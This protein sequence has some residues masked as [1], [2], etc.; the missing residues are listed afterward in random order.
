[1][2]KQ[3]LPSGLGLIRVPTFEEGP[4]HS[5]VTEFDAA[6]DQ[7]LDAPGL[8]LDLRG[9]SG[10]S[11][12]IS[13]RAAGRFLDESFTYGRESYRVRL[14]QRGWLQSHACR[15]R[16]RSPVYTGPV[17]VLIDS[18]TMS[19]AE[20]FLAVLVDSD[21][22]R[23]DG[24]RT[25]GGVSSSLSFR[26]PRGGVVQFSA[27]DFRRNDGTPLEGQGIAPDLAVSWTINDLRQGRDPDVEAAERMILGGLDRSP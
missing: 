13:D 27:S 4:G 5:L 26:L 9:N 3:R 19:A 10:G 20:H 11:T 18:S 1:M 12:T 23:T 8:I 14:P 25:G 15:V 17:V 6:L 22:V 24:R 16:S 7:L 21:R 2:P